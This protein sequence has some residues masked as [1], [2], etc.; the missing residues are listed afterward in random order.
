MKPQFEDGGKLKKTVKNE[1]SAKRKAMAGKEFNWSMLYMNVRT[2][3]SKYAPILK[4]SLAERCRCFIGS[5]QN[6]S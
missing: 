6:E 4:F 3:P 2:H 5:G 1:K